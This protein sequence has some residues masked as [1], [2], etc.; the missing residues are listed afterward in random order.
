[1]DND[2]DKSDDVVADDNG[3]PGFEPAP[4]EDAGQDIQGGEDAGDAG[5]DK[6]KKP[7]V[8]KVGGGGVAKGLRKPGYTPVEKL[9]RIFSKGIKDGGKAFTGNLMQLNGLDA[10]ELE[11]LRSSG[12]DDFDALKGITVNDLVMA[13]G[14]TVGFAREVKKLVSGMGSAVADEPESEEDEYVKREIERLREEVVNTYS[15]V[16]GIKG[17]VEDMNKEYASLQAELAI[18][19]DEGDLR[20]AELDEL[21]K[22][23]AEAY[24]DEKRI[25][26]ELLFVLD[27]KEAFKKE[28]DEVSKRLT[29]SEDGLGAVKRE[30]LFTQGE[31]NY[32]LEKIDYLMSKL[33]DALKSKGVSQQKLPSFMEQLRCV[34]ETLVDAYKRTSVGYYAN[35]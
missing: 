31:C 6:E 30:F 4:V 15:E 25:Q 26:D 13:A 24:F 33:D 5:A 14:V 1:M 23:E 27:E 17:D 2:K 20:V 3:I 18:V 29:Y 19:R 10:V 11:K 34:H 9:R 12:L 21:R 16:E 32:I 28:F 8:N 22:A 35:R 7:W